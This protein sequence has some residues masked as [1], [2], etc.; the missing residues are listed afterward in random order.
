M[1]NFAADIFGGDQSPSPE[2]PSDRQMPT[3]MLTASPGTA[4]DR[5]LNETN[6]DLYSFDM[7][8]PDAVEHDKGIANE[9]NS[10]NNR[11]MLLRS[12]QLA[13]T[14]VED[15]DHGPNENGGTSDEL[16]FD[17]ESGTEAKALM[18]WMRDQD[19]DSPD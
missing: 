12:S 4:L 15:D 11:P 9:A 6:I 14:D 1:P 13:P 16:N 10:E 2:K 18:A 7:S 19:G 8:M 17:W 5:I 3:Y